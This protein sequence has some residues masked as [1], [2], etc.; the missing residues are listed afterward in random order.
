MFMKKYRSIILVILLMMVLTACTDPGQE[1]ADAKPVIYLY[2]LEETE[3]TV[4]LDYNGTVTSTYPEYDNGW[5]VLASPDGT[6][7]DPETGR[8]YYCLFWEGVSRIDYDFSE[9]F[10]IPGN[11]TRKFLEQ[12]LSEM[13]LT[14]REANEFIIYWLPQMEH[15]AYNLI[16]FQTDIYMEN[17]GLEIYP[18]PDSL[19]R[20]FMAWKPLE[21]SIE[22]Q[23]QE[24]P[25]FRR[26]GYA[27]VE[28]GGAKVPD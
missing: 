27:V 18:E 21:E 4:K 5:T 17:A 13:G 20:V 14:D 12:V 25:A 28:W 11:E 6:L 16:S 2:P 10:V 9:G 3:I 1:Q 24:L 15:N 23:P 8:E 19:L 7:T 22:I 26:S